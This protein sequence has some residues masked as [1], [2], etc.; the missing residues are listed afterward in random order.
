[1]PKT[2]VVPLDESENSERALP[3]AVTLAR[4]L[5]ADLLLVSVF[6]IHPEYVRWSNT[7]QRDSDSYLANIAS[8]LGPLTVS[9]RVLTGVD[10]AI[11]IHE[12]LS[13]MDDPILVMSTHGRSGISR[14]VLGSKTTRIVQLATY[15]VI[16]VPP[17]CE[18][19]TSAVSR[20]LLPLDGSTFAEHAL[21]VT[22]ELFDATR[23]SFHLL[24][25]VD[26]AWLGTQLNTRF[27]EALF[28]ESEKYL[29]VVAGQLDEAGTEVTSVVKAS[30]NI[31]KTIA[32]TAAR[33]RATLIALSTHGR[34]GFS[35]FFLGS[36]ADAVLRSATMPV[37]VIRP[38]TDVVARAPESRTSTR[39]SE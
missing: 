1:M 21:H 39:T 30:N 28:E 26:E 17:E 12:A 22:L 11:E 15:P 36:V 31:A 2:I 16:V 24:R 37:L 5:N 27:Q 34:S 3:I 32:T 10:P 18:D 20:V 6:E 23:P 4:Q 7:Y 14:L 29:D 33:T 19:Y 25:V 9:T 8:R 13:E 35:R 38:S